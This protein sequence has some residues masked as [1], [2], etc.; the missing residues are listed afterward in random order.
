MAGEINSKSLDVNSDI[1]L[2]Y[3]NITI[4]VSKRMDCEKSKSIASSNE[5]D[6]GKRVQTEIVTDDVKQEAKNLEPRHENIDGQE[7]Y[8][9]D[10][11]K[12]YRVDDNLKPNTVYEI[13]S[14]QYTTDDCGRITSASGTLKLKNPHRPHLSNGRDSMET[15]GKGDQRATDNKFH[16]IGDRFDGTNGLENMIAG[17][18]KLNC[19]DYNNFEK[20]LAKAVDEGK[21]VCIDVKPIYHEDSHRP[22]AIVATYSINGEVSVRFF[23]NDS[24]VSK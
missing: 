24:E 10:Y 12:E 3:T 1:K 16:V 6:V 15:I 20:E 5:I 18:S 9:D 22:E 4:D 19:G 14:Y 17:D 21:T 8:Y 23:R 13:N 11:G 7:H 2:E